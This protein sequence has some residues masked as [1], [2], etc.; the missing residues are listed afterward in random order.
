MSSPARDARRPS[1][2]VPMPPPGTAAKVDTGRRV[3]LGEWRDILIAADPGFNRLLSAIQTMAAIG[4]TVG[5]STP[6]CS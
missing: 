2:A 4:V 1:A 6:S 5:S 3:R